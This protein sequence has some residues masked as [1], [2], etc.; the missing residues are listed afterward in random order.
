M[1]TRSARLL[2]LASTGLLSACVVG[3]NYVRPGVT[4]PPH[5]KEAEGWAGIQ[6][7]AS[8]KWGGVVTPGRT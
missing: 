5:F 2:V 1:M 8:L 7:S 3:P 6:P 4:T